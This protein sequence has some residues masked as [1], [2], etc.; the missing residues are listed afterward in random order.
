MLCNSGP[1]RKQ[2][3]QGLQWWI[4]TTSGKGENC[5]WTVVRAG[6]ME[7][8][9]AGGIC[10]H[11][12]NSPAR[13]GRERDKH[14]ELSHPTLWPPAD[15]FHM[16]NP[17]GNHGVRIIQSLQVN[18]LGHRAGPRTGRNGLRGEERANNSGLAF[19]NFYYLHG[20]FLGRLTSFLLNFCSLLPG[21]LLVL[22][23]SGN[24]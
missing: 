19:W 8:G 13:G 12:Q 6:V 9:P 14:P 3:T 7:K 11:F 2:D 24:G 17:M 18:C 15:T 1:E 21:E 16:P 10:S 5:H 4:V 23:G 20:E 22:Y